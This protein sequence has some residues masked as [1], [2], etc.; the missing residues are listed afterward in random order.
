MVGKK[1]LEGFMFCFV[2]EVTSQRCRRAPNEEARS[3]P[4]AP[5]SCVLM[6][7]C[8]YGYRTTC[9]KH[10]IPE[11]PIGHLTQIWY[12]IR[13]KMRLCYQ[14]LWAYIA[15]VWTQ[16]YRDLDPWE[17]LH[18]NVIDGAAGS[19]TEQTG[20]AG[21]QPIP[22]AARQSLGAYQVFQGLFLHLPPNSLDDRT[23][24]RFQ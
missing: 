6:H 21:C 8:Y 2:A 12:R 7:N 10:I 13:P 5:V 23:R 17:W 20:S 9:C 11:F 1:M 14:R 3:I 15:G 22:A 24:F 4:R 19:F 18:G 16:P